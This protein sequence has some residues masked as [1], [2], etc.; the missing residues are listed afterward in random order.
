MFRI[1]QGIFLL[2]ALALDLAPLI[3]AFLFVTLWE[4]FTNLRI[5]ILVTRMRF[6]QEGVEAMRPEPNKYQF[7]AERFERV[8]IATSLLLSW[9]VFHDAGWFF[10]WFVGAMLVVAGLTNI[11]PAALFG[12]YL[13]FR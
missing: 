13:G 12:R 8:L 10:P 4:A 3:N 6:G 1:I 7:E 2:S 9:V 11:C 5:P